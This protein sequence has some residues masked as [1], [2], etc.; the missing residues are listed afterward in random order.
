MAIIRKKEILAMNA[1]ELN[2][3]LADLRLELL[4]ANAQKSSKT[5]PRKVREIKKTIARILTSIKKSSNED[6]RNVNRNANLKTKSISEI[7]KLNNEKNK[8]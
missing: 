5:S 7:S 2:R 8:K 6:S 4:K 1:E 3:K